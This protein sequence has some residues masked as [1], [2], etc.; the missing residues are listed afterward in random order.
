MN[1]PTSKKDT[2]VSDKKI[3]PLSH[4]WEKYLPSKRI[5]IVIGIIVLIAIL[6]ALKN[7]LIALKDLVFNKVTVRPDLE[8]V[9]STIDQSKTPLSVDKDT[10]GDGL[11]DWQESLLGTD[12]FVVNTPEQVPE[13]LRQVLEDSEKL[14]TTDDKLTLKIYQRLQTD[15]KG[16]NIQEAIQA[17]TTKELL[18][19]ADSLDQQ[20]PVFTPDDIEYSED[21]SISDYKRQIQVARKI[22]VLS[23]ESIKTIYNSLFTGNKSIQ[24]SV[25]QNSLNQTLSD[26]QKIPAP[27]EFIENHI[28]LLTEM[29][30]MNSALSS[31]TQASVDES[32]RVALF[33]VF[34]KNYN[35]LLNTYSAIE[36]M[37]ATN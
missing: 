27:M 25:F 4:P 18:D 24:L 19:L 7:P 11:P 21:N 30:K 3:S 29:R 16:T 32:T 10:D 37:L 35:L 26:V 33:L 9:Q 13:T 6:Y 15:P 8:L 12:P 20:I 23:D 36:Q 28:L 2:A 14:V 17:A 34:Q 5:Q 22:V 1:T 31:N